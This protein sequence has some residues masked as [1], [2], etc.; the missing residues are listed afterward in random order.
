MATVWENVNIQKREKLRGVTVAD[1][2]VIGAGITGIM[3][4]YELQQRGFSVV[5]L[6]A[7]R[8]ASGASAC[9][10]AKITSQH[11]IIYSK[12]AR[13]IGKDQAKLYFESNQRAVERFEE[14]IKRE[15]IECEFRRVPAY[16]YSTKSSYALLREEMYATL[17]GARCICTRDTELPFEVKGALKF[18]NQAQ[19][20]PLK[21]VQALSKNLQIYEKSP[22]VSVE[23]GRVY[24]QKGE[25][26]TQ[27]I[28]NACHYPFIN[29]PGYYFLRQHQERSYL[30]AINTEMQFEGMYL[31]ID[32]GH[33]L[34][35]YDG[36]VLVGGEKHR[37]GK[38][39]K[40]GCYHRLQSFAK[41]LFPNSEIT[42]AWS[43]QD[44][45][46]HDGLPF[47]G[48][49]SR[50]HP[51]MY[52]ATGFNKWGMS[53]SSVASELIP[54]LICG[55]ANDYERVYTPARM[56]VRAGARGFV[57]DAGYSAVNL[58]SGLLSKKERKCTHLGCR[59]QKNPDEN[60]WECPCHGSQ[61]D[62]E[63]NV[64]FSPA[65]RNLGR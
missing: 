43:N 55:K 49:F 20:H 28:I 30:L 64:K 39:S 4:A 53:L 36:G 50:K 10:T 45:I 33:S 59:L 58:F 2:T 27:Y 46:T 63:G 19:F 14:I 5:V 52:V 40:G 6:E 41:D 62:L 29:F 16:L 34:R 38:N 3:I 21:F 47:I 54:D 13:K 60:T 51:K 18:E 1:C 24:T 23:E 35:S 56:N 65:K 12:I 61:F 9:T 44:I 17:S 22:V 8:V 26:R 15:K 7:D 57:E 48:K 37:T 11:G 31:D 32:S 42:H 25:V